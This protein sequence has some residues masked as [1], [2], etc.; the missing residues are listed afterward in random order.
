VAGGVLV[1]DFCSF[2]ASA[3]EL[4]SISDIAV[5]DIRFN[6][7]I[8]IGLQGLLILMFSR[9]KKPLLVR[10]RDDGAKSSRKDSQLLV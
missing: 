2:S 5:A 7:P 8:I 9:Q 10:I 6:V 4:K 1:V 3:G